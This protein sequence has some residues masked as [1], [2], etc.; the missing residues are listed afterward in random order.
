MAR[1]VT[2]WIGIVLT[3]VSVARGQPDWSS[4]FRDLVPLSIVP[5]RSPRLSQP[6]EPGTGTVRT[7]LRQSPRRHRSTVTIEP[8][9]GS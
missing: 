2:I 7:A 3:L 8:A 1:R 4:K 6:C 9:L 5:M